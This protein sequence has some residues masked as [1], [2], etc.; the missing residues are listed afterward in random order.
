MI[1]RPQMIADS[2]FS[3]F[4]LTL[5]MACFAQ[6]V[7]D[8]DEKELCSSAVPGNTKAATEWGICI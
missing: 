8:L 2:P 4:L 6:L 3:S 7:S 5:V 1:M